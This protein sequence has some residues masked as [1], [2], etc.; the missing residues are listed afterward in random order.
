MNENGMLATQYNPHRVGFQWSSSFSFSHTNQPFPGRDRNNNSVSMSSTSPLPLPLSS[1]E[2]D[3][4]YFWIAHGIDPET[5]VFLFPRL[6][7]PNMCNESRSQ[8][9]CPVFSSH[10]PFTLWVVMIGT[11]PNNNRERYSTWQVPSLSKTKVESLSGIERT[12]NPPWLSL[13]SG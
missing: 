4:G 7:F 13:N 8:V 12:E 1:W 9:I 11:S 2:E 3:K 10:V 5:S 6:A